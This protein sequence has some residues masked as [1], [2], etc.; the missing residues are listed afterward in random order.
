[1]YRPRAI[2]FLALGTLC[3]VAM[4]AAPQLALAE[5]ATQSQA[6]SA[7]GWQLDGST[8][9]YYRSGK[10]V[11]GWI[12]DRGQRYYADPQTGAMAIGW[13][14]IDGARYYFGSSGAMCTGFTNDGNAWYY[15][16][17]DGRMLTGWQVVNGLQR[18]FRPENGAM[19]VGWVSEGSTWYYFA[20][21]GSRCTGWQD[22]DGYRYY[23][24]GGTG[25]MCRGWIQYG[26]D[27]YFL[28]KADG[29]MCRGWIEDLGSWYFLNPDGTMHVGW[30]FDNDSWYWLDDEGVMATDT[31]VGDYCLGP[32]GKMLKSAYAFDGQYVGEDSVRALVDPRSVIA[33]PVSE[34]KVK[35]LQVYR[36]GRTDATR[37]AVLYIHGGAFTSG[38]SARHWRR[39]EQLA[40]RANVEVVLPAYPLAPYF[41][42]IDTMDPLLETWHLLARQYGAKNITLLGDSAGGC[43]AAGFCEWLAER[44]EEQPGHLVLV[45]PWLDVSCSN[46]Q[47]Q[48]AGYYG[49]DPDPDFL[50][51]VGKQW[52]GGAWKLD[53]RQ[54]DYRLVPIYGDVHGLCD[55]TIFMGDAESFYADGV[56]FQRKLTLSKVKSELVVGP[57]QGHNWAIGH[58]REGELAFSHIC[59]IAAGGRVTT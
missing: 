4:G 15:L 37:R 1:M 16:G 30:L 34:T 42:Y 27:W 36:L 38:V 24:Q 40:K 59:A 18:Y 25:V 5:P 3:A 47:V 54:M 22:I 58:S 8:W 56:V 57:D 9:Y 20:S 2:R 44:G 41:T 52:A 11:T 35:D 45:S 17:S 53:P 39:S 21:D 50:S 26:P 19:A 14:T 43:I 51:G 46:P 6:S 29:V 31:W 49:I 32:D 33:T 28:R 12:D 55:T 7:D 48:R 23:F 10:K 13:R